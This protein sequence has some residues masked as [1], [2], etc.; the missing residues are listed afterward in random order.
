MALSGMHDP[1]GQPEEPGAPVDVNLDV[2]ESMFETMGRPPSFA[3][4][5]E[6]M[7]RA[8]DELRRRRKVELKEFVSR[9]YD[10]SDNKDKMQYTTDM[11]HIM[12]GTNMRTHMLL[13]RPPKQFVTDE[14]GSRYIAYLEWVEFRLIEET[15][16]TV[17]A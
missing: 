8:M 15:V 10:L 5:A 4:S 6:E 16:P 3:P 13:D 12:L 9:T 14:N 1:L 17:G 2:G 11:E 7:A